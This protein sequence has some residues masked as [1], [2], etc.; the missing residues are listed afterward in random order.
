MASHDEAWSLDYLL[1][2]RAIK[3]GVEKEKK[4]YPLALLLSLLNKDN[5]RRELSLP[6]YS[7]I[8]SSPRRV[9]ELVNLIRPHG[10]NV[11]PD[12]PLDKSGYIRVF[13]LLVLQDIGPKIED[14]I[15]EH[16]TDAI[17]PL[18]MPDSNGNLRK[19]HSGEELK[20]S[21][22]W[23]QS[24]REY[25]FY[26]QWELMPAYFDFE[27]GKTYEFDKRV[28]LPWVEPEREE[29]ASRGVPSER[30]GA[31]GVVTQVKIEPSSH[32]FETIL[33][34]VKSSFFHMHT[35]GLYIGS[36]NLVANQ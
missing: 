2:D 31:F 13:T 7:N 3:H 9:D 12:T 22:H 36:I 5:L 1:R 21:A 10:P 6:S 8:N 27:H 35:G 18:E 16:E 30:E 25:F 26:R 33:K 20:A 15:K 29:V 11:K 24:K 32:T 23:H 14:F 4:F 19:S 17:F 28:I 34:E